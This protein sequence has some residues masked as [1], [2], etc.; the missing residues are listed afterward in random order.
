MQ[1]VHSVGIGGKDNRE[2]VSMLQLMFNNL[3]GTKKYYPFLPDV[4]SSPAFEDAIK[5]FQDDNSL[6]TEES[7]EYGL[8]KPNSATFKALLQ[9]QK[10]GLKNVEVHVY[11]YYYPFFYVRKPSASYLV[12]KA[13]VPE[14]KVPETLLTELKGIAA[15]LI[16]PIKILEP[17]LNSKGQFQIRI[18]FECKFLET[19][20]NK[21]ID[22]PSA[23]YADILAASIKLRNWKWSIEASG[24]LSLISAPKA[25]YVAKP[26]LDKH[27]AIILSFYKA[28][29]SSKSKYETHLISAALRPL[30]E[31]LL[32]QERERLDVGSVKLH[33]SDSK[34]AV[35]LA[36]IADYCRGGT[37]YYPAIKKAYD[38]HFQAQ[39]GTS[40]RVPLVL[41]FLTLELSLFLGGKITLGLILDPNTKQEYL[42]LDFE[43]SLA[44]QV[45][46]GISSGSDVKNMQVHELEKNSLDFSFNNEIA[47]GPVSVSFYFSKA[48][49]KMPEVQW[50]G[51]PDG[52]GDISDL[53][54]EKTDVT[55]LEVDRDTGVRNIDTPIKDRISKALGDGKSRKRDNKS[56]TIKSGAKKKAKGLSYPIAKVDFGP[57][58]IDCVIK[59]KLSNKVKIQIGPKASYNF[60]KVFPVEFDLG[61]FEDSIYEFLRKT[62]PGYEPPN[63]PILLDT[64]FARNRAGRKAS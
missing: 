37:G 18:Q 27:D 15:K 7:K 31:A 34:N 55:S 44:G 61:W 22:R 58:K 56:E 8:V 10:P 33:T 4:L 36:K 9:G 60:S 19:I 48:P 30:K 39:G 50:F 59:P 40:G 47:I 16:V 21:L 49:T 11:N 51:I 17:R 6:L 26:K 1:L 53:G 64:Q 20:T 12:P 35:E 3:R 46:G 25:A 5:A 54:T 29:A 63:T 38:A 41:L 32:K 2:D 14:M 43:A 62:L 57:V 42:Y 45:G 24:V 13:T 52:L 28:H 23:V